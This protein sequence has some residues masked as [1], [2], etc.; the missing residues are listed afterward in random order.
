MAAD[1]VCHCTHCYRI[2]FSNQVYAASVIGVL[3]LGLGVF[4]A[5]SSFSNLIDGIA[6]V[7]IDA[8]AIRNAAQQGAT[9]NAQEGWVQNLN[10]SCAEPLDR[11]QQAQGPI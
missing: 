10:Q 4:G 7:P 11:L 8:Q 6:A 3:G 1:L 2:V 9:V 5:G